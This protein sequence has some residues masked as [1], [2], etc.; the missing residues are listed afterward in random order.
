MCDTE[1]YGNEIRTECMMF[2]EDSFG[3]P[4]MEVSLEEIL[5]TVILKDVRLGFNSGT[6]KTSMIRGREG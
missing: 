3:K 6:N 2:G 4:K 5:V 1:Y